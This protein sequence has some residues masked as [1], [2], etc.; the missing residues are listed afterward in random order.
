MA[1][2]HAMLVLVASIA[3]I[4]LLA[5]LLF[6][7]VF[8]VDRRGVSH[9]TVPRQ[10]RR[11]THLL[12]VLGSGG[13][14]E[15]MI[16]MLRRAQ[17]DCRIYSRRTY[18]ISSG[19]AFSARKAAEFENNILQGRGV[20]S[21]VRSPGEELELYR[22]CACEQVAAAN[23]ATSGHGSESVP[24]SYVVVTVPRAR[25][26]HQS[27][28]TTPWSTLRCLWAC[29]R[30]LQGRHRDQIRAF[31]STSSAPPEAFHDYPG[32]ILTNG[33]GTAVCVIV[34]A[35]VLRALNNVVPRPFLHLLGI[36]P[37]D[38]S[39]DSLTNTRYLRTIFIE[40]WARVTTL[41]LSG[42]I[43]L[44]VVDRFLVQWEPLEGYSSWLGG[45]AE[46]AG[47]LVC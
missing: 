8:F 1:A 35:H 46:Y 30:I 5:A 38:H 16:S 9:E 43:V 11:P 32:V 6:T 42:K 28:L 22:P 24:S 17:L 36:H 27:F 44:P 29:L 31:S 10:P 37:R 33:P 15:E 18:V 13:H 40:S 26:V 21:K 45:K 41:S 14:T 4:T 3:I 39:L 47:T 2:F 25:K 23:D 20:R 7:V 34:A 12:I 19:D